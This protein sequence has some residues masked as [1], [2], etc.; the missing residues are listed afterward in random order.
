MIGND[1]EMLLS[2]NYWEVVRELISYE[3]MWENIPGIVN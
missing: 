3:K 2:I 1:F